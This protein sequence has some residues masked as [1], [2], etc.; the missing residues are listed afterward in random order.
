MAGAHQVTPD[1]AALG[2]LLG[3]GFRFIAYGTDSVAV[4]HALGGFA[5]TRDSQKRSD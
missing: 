2:R 5:Q 1:L 4:R 3:D